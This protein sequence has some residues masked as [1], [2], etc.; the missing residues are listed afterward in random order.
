MRSL[1]ILVFFAAFGSGYSQDTKTATAAGD[2]DIND[3]TIDASD[4]AG[5]PKSAQATT[6]PNSSKP[7]A[8]AAQTTPSTANVP[9]KAAIAQPSSATSASASSAPAAVSSAASEL[10]SEPLPLPH[11]AAI[12]QTQLTNNLIFSWKGT[13]LDETIR[14]LARYLPKPVHLAVTRKVSVTGDFKDLPATAILK[15][16]A[17]QN[18]LQLDESGFAYVLQDQGRALKLDTARVVFPEKALLPSASPIGA[19]PLLVQVAA[20]K[21]QKAAEAKFDHEHKLATQKTKVLSRPID[22]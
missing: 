22:N 16:V 19:Q 2:R 13:P 1:A 6:P 4:L 10:P 20:A 8:P 14:V 21:D 9:A 5:G 18:N 11:S 15:K 17:D 3:L 12:N 7:T